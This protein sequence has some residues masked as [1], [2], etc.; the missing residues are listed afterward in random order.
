[1]QQPL[2]ILEFRDLSKQYEDGVRAL[3]ELTLCVPAGSIFGFIGLNGA[4]KTTSIRILAGLTQKDAGEIVLFGKTIGEQDNSFKR[5]IGFVI[6]EPLY[7]EWMTVR[8][9]LRFVG[10]MYDLSV[11]DVEKRAD[12]LIDFF[13][14]TDKADSPIDTFSSGVKKKV[15]LA[16][17]IIQKPQLIVL[18]EPLEVI[19][20]VAASSIKESLALMASKG[21]TVLT[22][23]H[24][25]DTIE[26]FCT[27]VAII[28]HGKI[29]LQCK[30]TEI[31]SKAKGTL[32][33]QPFE[34]L[35][36]LFVEL[37]SDKVR[38]KH[39]SWL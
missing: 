13:D 35:E 4:G 34:S 2:N 30:T 10:W 37:V 15:S 26:K 23:S 9:Y 32:A 25:L 22:T 17:A 5:N 29:L 18:D 31:R 8:D 6:D 19:D 39:L 16:A 36:E 38:K 11:E 12:E 21:T 28:H 7:F 1:M 3:D 33:N 24:V 20:A 14:L 27:G